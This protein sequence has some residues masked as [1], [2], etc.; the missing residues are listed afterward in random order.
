AQFRDACKR[1]IAARA[2][3]GSRS[4]FIDFL[5]DSEIAHAPESFMDDEH[6]RSNIARIVEAEIAAALGGRREASGRD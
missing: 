5:V 2:R 6:Y 4:A 1:E 3:R